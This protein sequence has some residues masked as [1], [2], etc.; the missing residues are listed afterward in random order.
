MHVTYIGILIYYSTLVQT[1]ISLLQSF[2]S[3]YVRDENVCM[4]Y[5]LEFLYITQL[6]YKRLFHLYRF[7]GQYVRDENVCMSH[8][9][10]FLY[11]TQLSYKRIFHFYRASAIRSVCK[12]QE[13]V[14]VSPQW[15]YQFD[16]SSYASCYSTLVQTNVSR[17]QSFRDQ[18][19]RDENMC[20]LYL[21]GI[22]NLI[23]PLTP[24]VHVHSSSLE[25]TPVRETHT[26]E[27]TYIH[28]S[29]HTN[30]HT[31]M[32]MHVR[33][34]THTPT[35]ICIFTRIWIIHTHNIQL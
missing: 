16:L 26:Y 34:C 33:R 22:I 6:L 14:H 20:M 2:R 3:Q 24:L 13:C 27:H 29:T 23:P 12:R 18:Y 25:L 15:H 35:C 1:I 28:T 4:S 7:R 32:R 9:F 17:L 11:I 31:Q 5:I 30:T 10:K 8:V 19:V 21:S